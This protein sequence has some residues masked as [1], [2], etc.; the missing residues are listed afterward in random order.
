MRGVAAKRRVLQFGWHYSFECFELTSAAP[1]PQTL[2]S[3]RERAASVAAI[4]PRTSLRF[5]RRSTFRTL[6]KRPRVIETQSRETT[7]LA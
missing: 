5:S 1:M 4:P 6:R 3:V 7:D 2:S